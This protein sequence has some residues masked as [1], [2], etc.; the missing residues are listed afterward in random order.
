MSQLPKILYQVSIDLPYLATQAAAT[1]CGAGSIRPGQTGRERHFY[2]K[3]GSLGGSI[4][5]FRAPAESRK[6]K[7]WD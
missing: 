4:L 5:I 1:V 6:K 7:Y 3:A 2:G